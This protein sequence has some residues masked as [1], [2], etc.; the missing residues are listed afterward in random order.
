MQNGYKSSFKKSWI[1]LTVRDTTA[2]NLPFQVVLRSNTLS[3][4]LPHDHSID[5]K[6]VFD[7]LIKE[8]AGSRQDL[9]VVFRDRYVQCCLCTDRG[10]PTGAVLGYVIDMPAIVHVK[11]VDI[12]VVAQRPFPLVPA[13][14]WD[15][16]VAV[17]W[18]GVRR[19]GPTV[20]GSLWVLM[21]VVQRQGRHVQFLRSGGRRCAHAAMRSSCRS[22]QL[23]CGVDFLR[24]LHTGTGPGAVSTGTRLPQL[25]ACLC[26]YRWRHRR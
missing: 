15:S 8:C 5:A 14:H 12:T 6:S 23:G 17:H 26:R 19:P 21:P 20:A 7:A 16:P 4:R 9:P 2:G 25:G 13:D 24:A 3:K 18:Q 1:R 10:D 11:V 22:W